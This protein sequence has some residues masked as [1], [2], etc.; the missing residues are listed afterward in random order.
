LTG[1]DEKNL[2]IL[3]ILLS[4]VPSEKLSFNL[5]EISESSTDFDN[6]IPMIIETKFFNLLDVMGRISYST[7]SNCVVIYS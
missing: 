6:I 1:A 7:F 4:S 3:F 2:Y 5:S